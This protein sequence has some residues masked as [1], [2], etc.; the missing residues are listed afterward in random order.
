MKVLGIDTSNLVMSVAVMDNDRLLGEY[1]T[2]LKKNHSVR[3]MPAISLLLDEL[4][5]EP[6]NLDGIAVA[7]GPGSYTGTRIGAATAKAMAWSLDIPL[8][9]VSSLEAL[10]AAGAEFEGY[11]CPLFD[12]R[13]GQ[14]Y[15]A[16][17]ERGERK[18]EDQLLLVE[19]WARRL[20][21]LATPI[22]FLGDDAALHRTTIVDGLGDLARF[23][24]PEWN[25]PRASYIARKGIEKIERGETTDADQFIPQYLRLAEAEAKWLAARQREEEER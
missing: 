12:A 21:E 7:Q 9:G 1:T 15:T 11:V 16:L 19:T 20:A 22:L 24:P 3:L 17:F 10:A 13:R 6:A 2:N 4:E 25:V 5:L 8:V 18:E 14:A 23:A